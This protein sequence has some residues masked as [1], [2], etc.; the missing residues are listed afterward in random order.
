MSLFQYL[1]LSVEQYTYMAP[2]TLVD[3]LGLESTTRNVLR[4]IFVLHAL[5]KKD[6]KMLSQ[7]E[8]LEAFFGTVNEPLLGLHHLKLFQ[9]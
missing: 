2:C 1:Q 9:A 6:E 7:D 4:T 8:F 5:G 3:K